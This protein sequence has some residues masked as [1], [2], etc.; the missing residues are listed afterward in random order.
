MTKKKTEKTNWTSQPATQKQKKRV[1]KQKAVYSWFFEEKK[2]VEG[3]EIKRK[4]QKI[5]EKERRRE[6]EN[7]SWTAIKAQNPPEKRI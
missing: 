1:E 4:Q 5:R 6:R 3:R 7:R 2:L